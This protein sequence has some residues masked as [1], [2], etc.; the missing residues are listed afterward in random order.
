MSPRLYKVL[1]VFRI[2]AHATR[3]RRE[4]NGRFNSRGRATM[5]ENEQGL[6]GLDGSHPVLVPPVGWRIT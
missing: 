5:A 4:Q 3:S 6:A 2:K 1:A